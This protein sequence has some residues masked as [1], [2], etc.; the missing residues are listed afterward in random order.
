MVLKNKNFKLP[1]TISETIYQHIKKAII[2]GDLNPDQRLQEKEFAKVFNVSST[3]VREAFLR[4]SAEGYLVMNTRREVVVARKTL[5]EVK[6]LYEVVRALDMLAIKKS[7]KNFT[8]KDIQTLKKMTQKLGE[9]YKNKNVQSYLQQNLRF[10]DKVWQACK[11][12]YLYE[13]LTQLMEKI[14]IYRR[15]EEFSPFSEP[16][17]LDKSYKDHKNLMKAIEARNFE[18][19]EKL[20][21]SHW[22]EEF[23]VAKGQKSKKM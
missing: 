13:T 4:L 15:H 12:E 6:E 1:A 7:L 22:G 10:H 5:S 11:N 18:Q 23:F 19:L 2:E 14:A 20:I 8:Q 17:A 16:H 9:Y 3:P 21:S